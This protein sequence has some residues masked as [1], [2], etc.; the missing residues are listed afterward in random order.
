MP[1]VL[2]SKSGQPV[3]NAGDG[4]VALEQDI[5]PLHR[6]RQ[7]I[8]DVGETLLGAYPV[9]GDG[10]HPFFGVVQ[11][12]LTVAALRIVGAIGYFGSDSDQV[13]AD[14]SFTDDVA[15]GTNIGGAGCVSC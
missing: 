14:G 11:Q 5:D 4:V 15:I 12:L 8:L 3:A 1:A 9:F 13:A 6:A 2:S 7:Q 10:E